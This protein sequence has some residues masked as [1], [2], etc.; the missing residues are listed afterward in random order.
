MRFDESVGTRRCAFCRSEIS[1]QAKR[2]AET[3]ECDAIASSTILTLATSIMFSFKRML[4]ISADIRC[5]VCCSLMDSLVSPPLTGRCGHTI[6]GTCHNDRVVNAPSP[7]RW[8]PCPMQGCANGGSFEMQMCPNSAL[9]SIQDTISEIEGRTNAYIV[10]I[11]ERLG[12][13]S[14][15]D[16]KS[17]IAKDQEEIKALRKASQEKDEEVKRLKKK[18]EENNDEIKVLGYRIEG[19]LEFTASLQAR[20]NEGGDAL[21]PTPGGPPGSVMAV[22]GKPDESSLGSHSPTPSVDLNT[23]S[24]SEL[25]APKIQTNETKTTETNRK[26][27]IRKVSLGSTTRNKAWIKRKS[28][29]TLAFAR[30]PDSSSSSSSSSSTSEEEFH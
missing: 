10:D 27:R 6:C 29:R 2:I 28:A 8:M 7:R 15:S 23:D 22:A 3:N 11:T 25:H 14:I 4:G 21:I 26:L 1:Q 18:V 13:E 9:L 16:L 17:K 20:L 19:M 12:A 24:E 5:C 30:S